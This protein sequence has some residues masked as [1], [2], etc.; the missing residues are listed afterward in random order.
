MYEAA[1]LVNERP[2][3][4]HPTNPE[5]CNYL[6]PNDILLGRAISRVPGGPFKGSIWER[7]I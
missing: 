2:I 7:Q 4:K 6:C 5:E 3:G 1:T